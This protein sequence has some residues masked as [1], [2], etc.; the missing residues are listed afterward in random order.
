MRRML[1]KEAICVVKA[2]IGAVSWP[3]SVRSERKHLSHRLLLCHPDILLARE[4]RVL[5]VVYHSLAHNIDLTFLKGCK[6]IKYS[7]PSGDVKETM[8]VTVFLKGKEMT[9]LT[10]ITTIWFIVQKTDGEKLCIPLGLPISITYDEYQNV[11][12]KFIHFLPVSKDFSRHSS[13]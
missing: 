10:K 11:F 3:P 8:Q 6:N 4:G 7:I 2:A 9:I 1:P 5:E 13:S 12:C